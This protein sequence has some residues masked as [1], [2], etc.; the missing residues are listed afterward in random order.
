MHVDCRFL[1]KCC[2]VVSQSQTTQIAAVA[3]EPR[4]GCCTGSGV[5]DSELGQKTRRYKGNKKKEV[6]GPRV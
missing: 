4:T 2:L 1:K 3:L 5:T 6:K